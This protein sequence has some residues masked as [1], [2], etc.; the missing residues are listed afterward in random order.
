MD[1]Q[2]TAEKSVFMSQVN[3]SYKVWIQNDALHILWTH[4]SQTLHWWVFN[5]KLT[6]LCEQNLG[7]LKFY[8]VFGDEKGIFL[9]CKDESK[10]PKMGGNDQLVCH[11]YK[12][13]FM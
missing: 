1:K 11:T 12:Y 6:R 8:Q 5:G 7:Y 3:T 2:L 10:T 13:Q 9:W 4:N